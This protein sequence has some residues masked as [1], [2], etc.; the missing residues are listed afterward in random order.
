M[1][2]LGFYNIN[3]NFEFLAKKLYYNQKNLEIII[4]VAKQLYC[5]Y[6]SFINNN[7]IKK[8]CITL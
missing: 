4:L 1:I 6:K 7:T 5:N 8:S 3:I 2:G